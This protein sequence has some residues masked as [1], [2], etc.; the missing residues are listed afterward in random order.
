MLA[1]QIRPVLHQE[2]VVDR[3]RR[4]HVRPDLVELDSELACLPR[5]CS[6][7][8]EGLRLVG[9]ALEDYQEDRTQ[10]AAQDQQVK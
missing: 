10:L 7:V 5:S 6:E 8:E 2:R 4:R 3:Q 9:G 1:A